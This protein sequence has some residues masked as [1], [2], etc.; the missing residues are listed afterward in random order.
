MKEAMVVKA[1]VTEIGRMRAE[2]KFSTET[3]PLT[4]EKAI[5]EVKLELKEQQMKKEANSGKI[6]SLEKQMVETKKEKS[7]LYDKFTI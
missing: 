1:H 5:I 3:E 7:D 2:F 6:E 4:N